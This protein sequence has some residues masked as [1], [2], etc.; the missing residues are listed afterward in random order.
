[1]EQLVLLRKANDDEESRLSQAIQHQT[2]MSFK[3]QEGRVSKVFSAGEETRGN[4]ST[5]T[6][7]DVCNFE[8]S[9]LDVVVEKFSLSCHKSEV[10]KYRLLRVCLRIFAA[11]CT[12][13]HLSSWQS[14]LSPGGIGVQE[15]I[16]GVAKDL[17]LARSQQAEQVKRA[18]PVPM[19]CGRDAQRSWDH[20]DHVYSPR[21]LAG[22]SSIEAARGGGTNFNGSADDDRFVLR[23]QHQARAQR[24]PRLT[25]LILRHS[26]VPGNISWSQAQPPEPPG[27]V[28][29]PEASPAPSEYARI[30]R[31]GGS[32]FEGVT[33]IE[34]E[35][36]RF[37]HTLSI[38][39]LSIPPCTLCKA[40]S[41][42]RQAMKKCRTKKSCSFYW[43]LKFC[44]HRLCNLL[45]L[46]Q[47]Q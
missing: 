31:P 20:V 29:L 23:Q 44:K 18:G 34:A 4:L 42:C 10:N 32:E 40:L 38:S 9:K 36:S 6:R 15:L 3:S 33:R 26:S 12:S 35:P 19:I 7:G 27:D 46:D 16:T 41:I 47:T 45:K 13:G 11:L 25:G 28:G 5:R 22:Q 37:Q 30:L 14:I 43:A 8:D 2:W 1:M 24:F 17:D 39:H 21:G